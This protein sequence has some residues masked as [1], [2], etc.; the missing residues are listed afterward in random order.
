MAPNPASPI[1]LC[2]FLE[3]VAATAIAAAAPSA[4]DRPLREVVYKVS[5]T[6]RQEVFTDQFGVLRPT[7]NLAVTTDEGRITVDVMAV[8]E[9]QLAIKLVE[10]WHSHRAPATYLGNVSAEG[11]VNFGNQDIGEVARALLPFFG[12]RF[13]GY[14]RLDEG[15]Q[16]TAT[17]HQDAADTQ[18]TYV[19]TNVDGPIVTLQQTQ[20]I[21]VKGGDGILFTSSGKVRYEPSRL[22]P[23][24]ASLHNQALSTTPSSSNELIENLNFD[25]ISDTRDQPQ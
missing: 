16:W 25:R 17:S 3:I 23:I 6:N 15:A 19:V 13:T 20:S 5:Y 22:V 14:Q 12:A 9:T 1:K 21:V 7:P 2:M 8:S 4:N 24:S 10:D 18:T 11:M